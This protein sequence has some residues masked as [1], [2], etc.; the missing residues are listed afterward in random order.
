MSSESPD[1][2][3]VD[4]S[5][6][7]NF[8]FD[9]DDGSARSLVKYHQTSFFYS[10]T[11]ERE[12]ESVKERRE[13][14][15]NE[16]LEYIEENRLAEFEPSNPTELRPNDDD[17]IEEFIEKMV[18]LSPVEQVKRINNKLNQLRQG[19]EDLFLEPDPLLG[20]IPPLSRDARLMRE[21]E[22]AVGNPAD[23][24]IISDA[25]E[26]CDQGLGDHFLTSDKQ[27]I[28]GHGDGSNEAHRPTDEDGDSGLPD[29]FLGFVEGG[30]RSKVE[31]INEIIERNYSEATR[32]SF[33]SV[34]DFLETFPIA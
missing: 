11:V 2:A 4:T 22:A 30:N 21:L 6:C 23:R 29:S 7:Y 14:I 1:S 5:I 16:A 32:L 34:P 10:N 28:L 13:R 8:T 27:D 15:C 25:A 17:F 19:W 20:R 24:R 3:F 33:F 18:P 26:W 12:F 9:D 31:Q